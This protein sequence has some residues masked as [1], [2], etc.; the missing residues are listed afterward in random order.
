MRMTPNDS[1]DLPGSSERGEGST[2]G[3][4]GAS[5]KTST[6]MSADDRPEEAV[7]YL[8]PDE[9]GRVRPLPVPPLR[10]R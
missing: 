8:P 9:E 5:P 4:S 3:P 7:A 1:S 2:R 10:C 6:S